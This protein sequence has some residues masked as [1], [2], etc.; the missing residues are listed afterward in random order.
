[1]AWP[2][3]APSNLGP[4]GRDKFEDVNEL[5]LVERIERDR[6][7]LIKRGDVIVPRRKE[8]LTT[9]E[10]A[11]LLSLPTSAKSIKQRQDE[12]IRSLGGWIDAQ[13]HSIATG[14]VALTPDARKVFGAFQN[15][16][17]IVSAVKKVVDLKN[18]IEV[19]DPGKGDEHRATRMRQSDG[20]SAADEAR[21]SQDQASSGIRLPGART[22]ADPHQAAAQAAESSGRGPG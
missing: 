21:S 18:K 11:C 15:E 10:L 13:A 20:S 3:P 19:T 16:L 2:T 9:R 14:L 4:R 5:E 6:I 7:R 17:E 22:L 8:A 1:M 12:E